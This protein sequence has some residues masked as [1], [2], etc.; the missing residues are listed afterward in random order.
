MKDYTDRAIAERLITEA[1]IALIEDR[2]AKKRDA[3]L[4]VFL[5]ELNKVC[6]WKNEKPRRKT[7]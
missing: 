4:E 6:W 7:K 3:R 5:K 1:V 2:L